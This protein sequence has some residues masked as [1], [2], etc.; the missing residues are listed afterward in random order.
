V[1]AV[2]V[3]L[4]GQVQQ[5]TVQMV[6]LAAI[7]GSGHCFLLAADVALVVLAGTSL[8]VLVIKVYQESLWLR[9]VLLVL[10]VLV[11]PPP[12][13]VMLVSRIVV[14]AVAAVVVAVQQLTV[15]VVL[16]VRMK[17]TQV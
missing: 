8:L 6:M 11:Y 3:V 14:V 1:L 16:V 2:Q 15:L 10:A 5:V 4:G 17:P 7:V 9:L 12:Q 13:V